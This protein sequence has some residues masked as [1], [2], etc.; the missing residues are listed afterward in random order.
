MKK[1]VSCGKV[2]DENEKCCPNCG[3][4]SYIDTNMFKKAG[5]IKYCP[6]CGT[7]V[8]EGD[9]YCL[10]CGKKLDNDEWNIN[11]ESKIDIKPVNDIYSKDVQVIIFCIASFVLFC[12]SFVALRLAIFELTISLAT[13][14]YSLAKKLKE[15]TKVLAFI[16]LIMAVFVFLMRI[17]VF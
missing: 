8:N 5:T 2:Y 9:R 10:K 4:T 6:S 7:K 16:N 17:L 1:C 11:T 14:I 15:K 3:C 13:F 12:F